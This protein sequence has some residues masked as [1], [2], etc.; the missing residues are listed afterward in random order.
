M[1]HRDSEKS[2]FR[3]SIGN[4]YC[5]VM[6]YGLKNAS[7][8][9]QRTMTVIFHGMMHYEMEDYVDNIVVKSRKREDHIKVLK[10]VFEWCR[11]F[12]LRMN[13]LKSAFGVFA[14]K[15]LG[16]LVVEE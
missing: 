16:F 4:F 12:K 14:A 10:K 15:F 1:A 8:T 11:L 9:Y 2:A 5:T 6:P 3:T 7:V 13:L